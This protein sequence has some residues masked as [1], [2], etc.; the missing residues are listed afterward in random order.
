MN[1]STAIFL[2]NSDVRAVSVSYE[3]GADGKGVAPFYTFK[4]FDKSIKTGDLVVIPTTTR[5]MQTVVRVEAVDVEIDFDSSVQLDWLIDKVDTSKSSEIASQ[6]A[7]AIRQ[8]KSA[9][10][11]SKRD[12][13]ARKLM[14]DNTD[15]AGLS[16]VNQS[17]PALTAE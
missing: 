6:E 16:I 17:A 14:A 15:L 11:R 12:E 5:H 2:I 10:I 1:Y 3:R 8:I 4:T 9:E 13:M 7:E